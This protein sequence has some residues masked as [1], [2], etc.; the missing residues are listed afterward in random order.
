MIDKQ[1]EKWT[2]KIINGWI[3]DA[4]RHEKNNDFSLDFAIFT[5][6]LLTDGPTNGPTD[7]LMDQPTVGRTYSLIEVR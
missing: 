6:A 3:V 7:R 1:T 4:H 5:N 2:D